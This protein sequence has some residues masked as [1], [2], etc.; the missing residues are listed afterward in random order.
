MKE[1]ECDFA[2]LCYTQLVLELAAKVEGSTCWM[3]VTSQR[4]RTKIKY[5]NLES[6]ETLQMVQ[7]C[8]NPPGIPKAPFHIQSFV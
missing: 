3:G 6:Y 4:T 2:G 8:C 7:D 5:L 1:A